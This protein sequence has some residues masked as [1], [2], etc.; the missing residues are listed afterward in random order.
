MVHIDNTFCDLRLYIFGKTGKS[1]TAIK[2]LQYISHDLLHDNC[3]LEIIDLME[4][5]ERGEDDQ[6]LATPTLIRRSP[7]PVR[8][9]I[10][11]LSDLEKVLISL[12]LTP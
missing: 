10:G 4:Q 9:I 6:I 8:R 5:P 7:T 1:E 3:H 12:E 2:T 11:D